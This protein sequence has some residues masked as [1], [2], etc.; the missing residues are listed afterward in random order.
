MIL[1]EEKGIVSGG[2]ECDIGFAV[3]WVVKERMRGEVWRVH[4][5]EFL[6]SV[7]MK[8]R[9]EVNERAILLFL[10]WAGWGL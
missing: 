1:G 8:Q 9:S 4:D 6:F 3:E 10:F 2:L 7:R 5:L